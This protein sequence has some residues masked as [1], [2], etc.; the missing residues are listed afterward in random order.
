[1]LNF[2]IVKAYVSMGL[3]DEAISI[4]DKSGAEID[5]SDVLLPLD[6]YKNNGN[7][8]FSNLPGL[9]T[10][11]PKVSYKEIN[12]LLSLPDKNSLIQLL[13]LFQLC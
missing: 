8:D 4:A 2:S 10:I 12:Y 5:Y 7:Y 1:M 9:N 6:F 13:Y 11:D 3:F